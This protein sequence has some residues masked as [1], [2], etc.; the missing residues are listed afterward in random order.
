MKRIR[1]LIEET[2]DAT[3][4]LLHSLDLTGVV[5]DYNFVQSRDVFCSYCRAYV[6]GGHDFTGECLGAKMVGGPVTTVLT[7]Q[8]WE[9]SETHRWPC[10]KKD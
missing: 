7:A 8:G 3:G 10:E 5:A 9:K 6:V 4:D 2:E 1:I